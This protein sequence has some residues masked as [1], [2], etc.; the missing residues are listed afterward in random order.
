MVPIGSSTMYIVAMIRLKRRHDRNTSKSKSIWGSCLSSQTTPSMEEG[1]DSRVRCLRTMT[2]LV[3]PLFYLDSVCLDAHCWRTVTWSEMSINVTEDD[4]SG[5]LQ[6]DP[7]EQASNIPASREF[8]PIHSYVREEPVC[9]TEF[10]F[11]TDFAKWKCQIPLSRQ[12]LRP[13]GNKSLTLKTRKNFF[14]SETRSSYRCRAK[15]CDPSKIVTIRIFR[16]KSQAL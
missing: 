1:R 11:C 16:S 9:C 5:H 13:I 8:I 3:W 7:V 2:Q 6:L 10:E 12:K 15:N 4:W 14:A